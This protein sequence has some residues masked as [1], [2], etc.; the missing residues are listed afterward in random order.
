MGQQKSSE[1]T[2]YSGSGQPW[3]RGL[4]KR[5]VGAN[6]SVFD[7]QGPNLDRL[8]G[9]ANTISDQLGARFGEGAAGGA[10]ARQHF[11]DLLSRGPQNN[12][13]LDQMLAQTRGN[14]TNDVNSQFSLA[15]RYGSDAHG[16]G[17]T[18]ELANAENGM[19]YQD[20]N[21]QTARMDAGANSL[22][23]ANQGEAAQALGGLGVAAELPW[24]GSNNLSRNLA[25][26]FSGGQSN[27]VSYAP[28]PLW[29]ALGAG[30]GAAG[31][32]LGKPSDIRLKTKVEL[33]GR[34]PDGLG[35]YE[36]NWKSDPDGVREKGVLAHE[37][38][39]LRPHAYIENYRD[40]YAGVNYAAL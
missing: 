34:E 19:R 13:Y 14:I 15:G 1:S 25:A 23:G 29:G 17:L 30:L 27:S 9:N 38:K 22:T 39:E 33:V 21:T 24:T 3:A 16:A 37:V 26:L 28:N 31:M 5:G 18:R 32:A 40:G 2:S 35:I 7:K 20:Y 8:S 6:F 36:W 10:Q 12:P 11:M 4:A